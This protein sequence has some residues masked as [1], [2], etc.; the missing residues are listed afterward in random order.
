MRSDHGVL[1]MDDIVWEVPVATFE[2]LREYA[3]MLENAEISPH[4]YFDRLRSLGMPEVPRGAHL[5]IVLR[6]QRGPSPITR[7]RAAALRR[8]VLPGLPH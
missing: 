2:T 1:N 6:T 4:D 3:G 8:G 7:V 5:R